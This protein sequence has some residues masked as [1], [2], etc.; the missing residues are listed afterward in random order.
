MKIIN[1]VFWSIF[2][3]VNINVA[4]ATN[5]SQSNKISDIIIT[6]AWVRAVAPGQTIGAAYMTL[7]STKNM[8]LINVESTAARNVEIHSM[9]MTNGVMKMRM[10][11][12][13][14][15]T[16]NIP[17]KL[18]PGGFHLMLFN[19][20]QPLLAGRKVAF[21]L[22]FKDSANKDLTVKVTVPIKA[23]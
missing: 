23:E 14:N 3:S 18:A 5:L 10:L 21:I 13:L 17:Y 2:I 11:N 15:L 19:L 7:N 1:F 8:A 9:S 20:K 22:H 4:Q 6:D 12:K 16:A